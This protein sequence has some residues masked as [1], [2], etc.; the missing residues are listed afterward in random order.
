MIA[1]VTKAHFEELNATESGKSEIARVVRSAKD[2][3]MMHGQKT[4]LFIDEIH[5]FNKAQQDTLLPH[6]EQG[7]IVLIGATT[8]NPYYEIND[9]LISRSRVFKLNSINDYHIRTLLLRALEQDS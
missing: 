3:L 7:I 9:A 1:N 2:R 6:V 8:Q 4:I 5:R